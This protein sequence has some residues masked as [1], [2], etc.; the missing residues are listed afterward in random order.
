MRGYSPKGRTARAAIDEAA[1]RRIRQL[2]SQGQSTRSLADA[3]GITPEAIRRILRYDTWRWV[4]EEGPGFVQPE[5]NRLA[6]ETAARFAQKFPELTAGMKAMDAPKI[7]T[8]V[9]PMEESLAA[10]AHESDE[11]AA[12]VEASA[13][14]RALEEASQLA[15]LLGPNELQLENPPAH[16]R[17]STDGGSK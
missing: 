3:Y 7:A 13:K 12:R 1:V 6:A 15:G 11:V 5:V 2:G 17:T 8:S 10:A 16:S 4:S 9:P 14:A